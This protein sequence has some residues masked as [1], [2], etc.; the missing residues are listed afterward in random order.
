MGPRSE[1]RGRMSGFRSK[2]AGRGL[3]VSYHASSS[4]SAA[5]I[6]VGLDTRRQAETELRKMTL[7]DVRLKEKGEVEM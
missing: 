5:L 6:L 4:G 7:G 3:S 2:S 1:E